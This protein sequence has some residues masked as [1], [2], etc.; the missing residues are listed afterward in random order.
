MQYNFFTK[1]N[2]KIATLEESSSTFSFYIFLKRGLVFEEVEGLSYLSMYII[3]AAKRKNLD[4]KSIETFCKENNIEYDY[5]IDREYITISFKSNGKNNILSIINKIDDIFFVD[6]SI[7]DFSDSLNNVLNIAKN[8]YKDVY[9]KFQNKINQTMFSNTKLA[10]SVF[11]D[12]DNFK[13]LRLQD[14]KQYLNG[15]NIDNI[16]FGFVNF[17]ENE[18]QLYNIVKNININKKDNNIIPT[19]KLQLNK[20]RN[21]IDCSDNESFQNLFS[22]NILIKKDDINLQEELL[23]LFLKDELD[24]ELYNLLQGK[25][26][27]KLYTN[28]YYLYNFNIEHI[29]AF[30][31][32]LESKYKNKIKDIDLNKNILNETIFENNKKEYLLNLNDDKEEFFRY[33]C[34]RYLYNKDIVYSDDQY[35]QYIENITIDNIINFYN[36]YISNNYTTYIFY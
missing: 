35:R 18:D 11:N 23:F 4:N 7:I 2:I 13:S 27:S 26:A 14:V 8:E 3:F 31:E 6:D 24:E 21:L 25:Y 32:V 1:N 5:E 9:S 29:K 36:N 28:S 33:L 19:F 17:I 20:K 12:K 34:I 10:Y 16:C 30:V 22:L 15:I